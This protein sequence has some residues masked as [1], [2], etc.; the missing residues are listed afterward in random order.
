MTESNANY[1]REQLDLDDELPSLN[2]NQWPTR[3]VATAE[4]SAAE[5]AKAEAL[6]KTAILEKLN[7]LPARHLVFLKLTPPDEDDLYADSVRHPNVVRVLALSGGYSR[8]EANDRLR[9]NHGVVASFSRALLDGLSAQQSDS[10][11]NAVLDASIRSIFKASTVK[12][13]SRKQG[14]ELQVA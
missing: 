2:D 7:H 8:D 14:R 10:E 5:K 1:Q 9:R 11:F 3:R 12:Q 6:L 13:A 4:E